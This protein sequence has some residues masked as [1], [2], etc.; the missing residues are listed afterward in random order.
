MINR[1]SISIFTV[2]ILQLVA[3]SSVAQEST[4]L[5]RNGKKL[6][7]NSYVVDT[8]DYYNGKISYVTL[9]GKEKNKYL[10]DVF[11]VVD[12]DGSETILYKPNAELGEILT[13][14][15][16]KEYTSGIGDAR[17]DKI[18]PLIGIGAV[19]SG[20]AGAFV[21]QPQIKMGDSQM[22]IPIGILVP[23]AY[24]ATIG[25]TTPKDNKLKQQLPDKANNVHY[26]MGYQE[27][28]KRKRIKH[29]LIGA[30]IG[31]VTGFI[32]ATSVN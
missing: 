10:E 8:A 7:I 4:L 5:L 21:P 25:E 1:F 29:S 19:A 3:L 13:P 11:S 14:A 22:G 9:K 17:I 28:V 2:I 12:K 24:T 18:S 31:F 15:Q 20:L 26:L 6:T 27:G 30:S 23:I 16:M 32:I